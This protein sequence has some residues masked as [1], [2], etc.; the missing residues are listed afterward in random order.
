MNV[1]NL[2]SVAVFV[3]RGWYNRGTTATD[4]LVPDGRPSRASDQVPTAPTG[5]SSEQN[6]DAPYGVRDLHSQRFV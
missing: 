1:W 5:T 4:F 3:G 6:R 2:T